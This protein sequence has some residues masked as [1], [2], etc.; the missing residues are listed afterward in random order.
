MNVVVRTQEGPVSLLVDSIG[1][2]VEVDEQTFENPPQTLV[3]NLR[4]LIIGVHKLDQGLLH[5][6]DVGKAS[7]ISDQATIQ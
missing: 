6:V 7:E 3:G 1:N 2:V 5:I 4:A